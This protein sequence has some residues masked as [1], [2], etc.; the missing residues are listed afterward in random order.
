M[1]VGEIVE[2]LRVKSNSRGPLANG[3]IDPKSL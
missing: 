1:I 3:G 2:K